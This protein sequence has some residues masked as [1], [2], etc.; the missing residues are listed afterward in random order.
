MKSAL[1]WS[2]ASVAMLLLCILSYAFAD[3]AAAVWFQQFRQSG[4]Y[5]FFSIITLFG[6]SLG[7][8]IGGALLFL[9]CRN[10][11]KYWADTG[12]FLFSTVAASGL[13]ADLIKYIAGRARPIL[14]F[15]EHHFGFTFFQLEKVWTSFPSGHSATALSVAMLLALL[16]PQWR[17]FA[18]LAGFMVAFSRIFLVQH[19]IS[20]V[21][22]GSFL[23]IASTALLYHF[24]FKSK[25][26]ESPEQKTL[27]KSDL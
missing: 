3:I 23:G 15:S 14:Y 22:A 27:K 8:L 4:V 6:D 13:T 21:L 9:I 2:I 25:L 7:Y 10:K 1:S 18:F 20:D 19:Y 17:V 12:L 26:K 5:D 24:Y 16:F 11:K